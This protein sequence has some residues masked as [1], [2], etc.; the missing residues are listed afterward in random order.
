MPIFC[1]GWFRTLLF[2]I[3]II[4][5]KNILF[6]EE[7]INENIKLYM[8][9]K[10]NNYPIN[11]NLSLENSFCRYG[12][13]DDKILTDEQKII[14][15][16]FIEIFNSDNRY[17]NELER[18]SKTKT[19]SINSIFI[20]YIDFRKEY[21][22]VLSIIFYSDRKIYEMWQYDETNN[23]WWTFNCPIYSISGNDLKLY[24]WYF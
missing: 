17:I 7:N 5:N 18:Q 13:M 16:K 20:E 4:A 2:T 12:N 8:E 14:L 21:V 11:I 15:G 19:F 22:I 3:F 9:L 10:Y 1:K 6:A 23:F 24:G